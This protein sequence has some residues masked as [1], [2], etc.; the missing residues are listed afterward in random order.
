MQIPE[1]RQ[2][3]PRERQ[4]GCRSC[5]HAGPSQSLVSSPGLAWGGEQG[6]KRAGKGP[7]LCLGDSQVGQARG[8]ESLQG[9][10]IPQQGRLV[11]VLLWGSQDEKG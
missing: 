1:D 10:E 2:Q 5:L 7:G 8:F 3:V 4:R 9:R 11:E 6:R